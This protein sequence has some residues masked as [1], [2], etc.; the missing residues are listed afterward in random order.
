MHTWVDYKKMHVFTTDGHQLELTNIVCDVFADKIVAFDFCR[1]DQ[2][3][4]YEYEIPTK[5]IHFSTEENYLQIMLSLSA[6]ESFRKEVFLPLNHE[7]IFF[8]PAYVE[9]IDFSMPYLLE[10]KDLK[11]KYENFLNLEIEFQDKQLG[12]VE[13]LWIGNDHFD[14]DFQIAPNSS[15]FK[16]SFLLS[17]YKLESIDWLQRKGFT[18]A[19]LNE[20]PAV[21]PRPIGLFKNK[22][23]EIIK[24]LSLS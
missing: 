4:F 15:E 1:W 22:L 8:E 3:S 10:N 5:Y 6:L 14:L 13:E 12:R 16:R 19:K 17:S 20:L 11:F 9:F 2:F 7:N 21:A 23:K 24:H 18:N